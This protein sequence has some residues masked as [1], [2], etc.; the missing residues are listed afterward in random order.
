MTPKIARTYRVAVAAA[1]AVLLSVGCTGGT[2]GDGG[3]AAWTFGDA[4]GGSFDS[5]GTA[6]G[7]TTGGSTTGGTTGSGGGAQDAGDRTPQPTAFVLRN[8]SDDKVTYQKIS[9]D[10]ENRQGWVRVLSERG[11]IQMELECRDCRCAEVDDGTCR[12]DDETC[13]CAVG[14]TS[15][16]GSDG[17]EVTVEWDGTR[18]TEDS[19]G[20]TA[21]HREGV[22]PRGT[23]MVAEFCWGDGVAREEGHDVVDDVTCEQEGFQYGLRDRVVHEIQ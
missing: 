12:E 13:A 19:S 6:T 17:G 9:A 7:G 1:G 11:P 20:E 2:E 18:W 5:G 16:L 15:T 21:C 23:Q 8:T 22:P 10:C 3:A 4:S 14:R